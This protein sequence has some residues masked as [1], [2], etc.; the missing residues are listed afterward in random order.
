MR[1]LASQ[2]QAPALA[3]ILTCCGALG[4]RR[5]FIVHWACSRGSVLTC[6]RRN[7]LFLM[8]LFTQKIW[9]AVLSVKL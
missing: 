2:Q 9:V 4:D 6:E 3:L 5:V 1:F 7:V 8:Q